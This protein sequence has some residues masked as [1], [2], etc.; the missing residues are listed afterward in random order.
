[1]DGG[2]AA[3]MVRGRGSGRSGGGITTVTGL[4]EPERRRVTTVTVLC[5]GEGEPGSH[6]P[7]VLAVKSNGYKIDFK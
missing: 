1:M 6:G 7:T 5:D 2:L 3:V 4:R